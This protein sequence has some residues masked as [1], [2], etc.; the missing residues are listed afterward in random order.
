MDSS[1][2]PH[3]NYFGNYFSQDPGPGREQGLDE[4]RDPR[5][6]DMNKTP[7]LDMSKAPYLDV[8]R[9]PRNLDVNKTPA[10][11]MSKSLVLDKNKAS[12][13]DVN[14]A[15]YLDVLAVNKAQYLDVYY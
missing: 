5:N 2:H 13:L 7:A 3:G 14:K 11:D 1:N 6:L 8:A 9:D 4:A 15:Q 12:D 10:V